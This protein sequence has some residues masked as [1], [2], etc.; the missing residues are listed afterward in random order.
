M[1]NSLYA[2]NRWDT[3]TLSDKEIASMSAFDAH[4]AVYEF[5]YRALPSD[6]TRAVDEIL[7]QSKA[8]DGS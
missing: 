3:G 5:W 2:T 6:F 8:R 7:E 1:W 4:Q